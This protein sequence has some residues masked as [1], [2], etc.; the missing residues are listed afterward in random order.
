MDELYN[1]RDHYFETHTV[2]DAERKQNDVAAE[3]AKALK[4]LEKKEGKDH[5]SKK[6]LSLVK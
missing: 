4:K 6:K 3:M 5:Y 2:E 1:F